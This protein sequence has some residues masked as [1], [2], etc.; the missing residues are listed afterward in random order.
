MRAHACLALA[1]VVLAAGCAR[2]QGTAPS[3]GGGRPTPHASIRIV[4][5]GGEGDVRR[6]HV[7]C[8]SRRDAV[9]GFL[10]LEQPSDVCRRVAELG[11]F[12]AARPPG[13]RVCAQ[14]YG[15]PE[16]ARFAGRFAGRRVDR[17]FSR[18]DACQIKDWE[19]VSGLLP[20]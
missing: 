13:D 4:Y 11:G 15:G 9:T 16:R 10:R 2:G 1:L 14:V 7:M 18:T 6:A 5:N 20:H 12:L 19:R 17:R 8:T 3:H